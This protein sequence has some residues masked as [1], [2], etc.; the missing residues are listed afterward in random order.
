MWLIQVSFLSKITPGM[1][2]PNGMECPCHSGIS[3][4]SSTVSGTA[5]SLPL[6]PSLQVVKA[7]AFIFSGSF[8]K[9]ILP[10]LWHVRQ[11]LQSAGIRLDW[12]FERRVQNYEM[13]YPP[14][15]G[16]VRVVLGTRDSWAEDEVQRRVGRI[17]TDGSK[18]DEGVG[19]AFVVMDGQ[20]RVLATG[21][22]RLS[23]WATLEWCRGHQQERGW[24]VASDSCAVLSNVL[25]QRR[26][27][28]I[29]AQAVRLAG[30]CHS[31][32][33]VPGHQGIPGNEEADLDVPR[34]HTRRL[35]RDYLWGQWEREWASTGSPADLLPVYK[36]FA[37][38]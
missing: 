32:V 21:L 18:Q 35:A 16:E 17:F 10:H 9:F 23:P 19:A 6:W 7:I 4:Q 34:A 38:S 15:R 20:G 3:W 14:H 24:V 33:Y 30:D 22:L 26:L 1:S 36:R 25:S 31:L 28:P 37:R 29:T 8:E 12:S 27:T 13:G 5:M 2:A 11:L